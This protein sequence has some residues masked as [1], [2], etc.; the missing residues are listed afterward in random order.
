MNSSGDQPA[1]SRSKPSTRTRV[2]AGGL[3][4]LGA[5]VGIEVSVGG[6]CS[7]RSTAIGCGSKVTATTV[8]MPRRSAVSR[9]S[10]EHVG[11]AEVY[12]VEVADADHGAAEVGRHVVDS[13]PD[14]HGANPTQR[15][16]PPCST[17]P[18]PQARPGASR[19]RVRS[20]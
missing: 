6:A 13:T 11:V 1:I 7:G 14:L 17:G 20:A 15:T 2:D 18:P 16:V 5:R 9:A 8:S 4:Q 3:E 10:R 19:V 12:A